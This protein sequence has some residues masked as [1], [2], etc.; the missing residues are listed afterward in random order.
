MVL[1]LLV[2][3]ITY[4]IM[5][6]ITFSTLYFT[7]TIT[8]AKII[9]LVDL[10]MPGIP[11]RH[12]GG[13]TLQGLR[14]RRAIGHARATGWLGERYLLYYAPWLLSLLQLL[15]LLLLLLPLKPE[16][17]LYLQYAS[18]FWKRTNFRVTYGDVVRS[19]CETGVQGLPI[20][21]SIFSFNIQ[22]NIHPV[23]CSNWECW[24]RGM[25]ELSA[26][27]LKNCLFLFST[28]DHMKGMFG[29]LSF[30]TSIRVK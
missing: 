4:K 26:E 3:S 20:H 1:G 18:Y 19:M 24:S 11:E 10:L 13:T 22:Y 17:S 9:C 30:W 2:I 28:V 27:G 7:L 14:G 8:T 5:L 6:I 23:E 12:Y 29:N 15:P 21:I 16:P 25:R